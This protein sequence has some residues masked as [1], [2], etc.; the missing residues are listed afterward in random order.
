VAL[1]DRLLI[2]KTDLADA[3]LGALRRRLAALNAAAPVLTVDHGRLD[4]RQ[5]FDCRPFDPHSRS[6][7]L[8]SWLG[9]QAGAH[10][11][12][13]GDIASYA[14]VRERPIHAVALTLFL[15][16]LAEH[17]GAGLLRLKGIVN[18]VESPER[19][20]VI[21]GV[22]HVFHPPAWLSRW[23]SDDRRSRLVFI[24]RAIPRAWVAALLRALEAEVAEVSALHGAWPHL[25][26]TRR[27]SPL[28][29]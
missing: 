23:P 7:D 9:R 17:C 8:Q 13:D 1:A 24:T 27:T 21:H 16:A 15:E 18:L 5:L 4:P 2:T 6:F 28:P 25:G 19:P 3:A 14:I 20:A 29:G 10:S 26:T 11:T 22:Q 12:H